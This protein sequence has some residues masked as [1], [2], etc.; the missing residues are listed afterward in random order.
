[1]AGAASFVLA[2]SILDGLALIGAP[3]PDIHPRLNLPLAFERSD[4]TQARYV[5]RGQGYMIA[6]D[7]AKATIAVV[8]LPN[9][10][11]SMITMQF[12]GGRRVLPVAGPE[13][14]GKVNY[15]RG[16][17][18]GK[19]KIGVPTCARVA[20]PNVYPGVDV[21]YYG[22]Q[23]QL[24]FDLV[25]K[26]G[27]D[28]Q[29]IRMKFDGA[30]EVSLDPNGDLVLD[31]ASGEI[32]LPSPR[33]YQETNGIRKTVAGHY[34]LRRR[35]EVGFEVAAYDRTS[36]LIIDPTIAFAAVFGGS[37]ESSAQ[38]IALNS[39]H[40][41]YVAGYTYAPDFPTT[42]GTAQPGFDANQ[43]GFVLELNAAGT[44]IIYST[45]L[46]GSQYD[47]LTGIAVDSTGA[48]WVTGNTSSLDFPLANPYQSAFNGAGP[49][50][51]VAK[52]SSSGTLEFSSYLLNTNPG[53]S[54]IAVDAGNN[55]YVTGQ[56]SINFPTTPGIPLPNASLS[57]AFVVKFTSGA[58]VVYSTLLGG[59][60]TDDAQ[61]IAA[62]S[63]GNA[64]VTGYTNSSDFTGDPGGGAHTA[65]A[66]GNDAFV[67][68]L[69]PSG[70][71][72]VYFTFLGGSSAD[73]SNAIAIDSNSP[74]NAYIGG[75]TSSTNFPS[76]AGVV[77]TT[78]T[79]GSNG[80]VAKLNGTGSAFTYVTYLGGNRSDS[81]AAL[82]LEPSSG[83]VYV[84]GSTDSSTLPNV[85]AVEGYPTN[86]TSLF[87]TTS[88]TSWSAFDT[89]IPGVVF[90]IA[91]DPVHSGTLVVSTDAGIYR[92]TNSGS[93]W[94][95]QSPVAKAF[96]SRSPANPST[97]YAMTVAGRS[98]LSTD[99]GVT[100]NY[101]G[102]VA[103]GYF[104]IIADPLNAGTAYAYPF[105]TTNSGVTWTDFPS[106]GPGGSDISTLFVGPD[107]TLYLGIQEYGVYQST[108][109]GSTWTAINTGLPNAC[110]PGYDQLSAS[111]GTSGNVLY[112]IC[113]GTVYKTTNGG[114][115][116]GPT[117]A[118]FANDLVYIMSSPTNPN[119]VYVTA[120]P[121]PVL[122]LSS[123]GGATWNSAATGLGIASIGSVVF[124]PSSANGAF[125]LAAAFSTG[126]VA[127]LK[128]AAKSLMY[129]SYLGGSAFTQPN[130]I[131][132]NG[133][134]EA[135]VAGSAYNLPIASTLPARPNF[136]N[137]FVAAITDATAACSY[138]IYP[139][140]QTIDGFS[141]V[142]QSPV[143]FGVNAPSGCAWTAT[144]NQSWATVTSGASGTGAGIVTVQAAANTT[145][146]MR[147]ASISINT[148]KATLIQA[149]MSCSFTLGLTPASGMFSSSGGSGQL[150]ISTSSGCPWEVA[151]DSPGALIDVTPTSGT[152]NGNV[153]FTVLP[154][155]GLNSRSL[156]VTVPEGIVELTQSGVCTSSF[157][158][159]SFSSNAQGGTTSVGITSSADGC[160]WTA[161][162]NADWLYGSSG[163][164]SGALVY[165]IATNTGAA[166]SGTLSLGNQTFTVNQA[167][168]TIS[169]VSV[170][171]NSE[172]NGFQT[173]AFSFDDPNGFADLAVVNVLINS[174]LDGIGACYIAFAP[175]SATSGYLYLV[176]DA[177]DG[178]YA[179]GS[180]IAFPWSG[181]LQNSQCTING[182]GS[183][184]SASGNTLTLTLSITF[185]SPSFAG[186]RVIYMAARNSSTGNS[187]WQPMGTWNVPGL[188]PTGPTVEGVV[189]ALNA[190]TGPTYSFTF[191]DTNGYP[192]LAVVNVL[193]N[194]SLDGIGA[195]YL[196]FAP[197]G[198]TTGYLYLVDDAGDGGYASGSPIALPSSGTLENSQ[199]A[200]SANGSSVSGNSNALTLN[201]VI[202]FSSSFA[203]NQV[204]Y[205][206]ARNNTTGNS[207]WQPVGSVTVP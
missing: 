93:T 178:G 17:D 21:V 172:S 2:L 186:N 50:G 133:M 143:T 57:H 152:G 192:D 165:S 167:A 60:G 37:E 149:A 112:A 119:L 25:L 75:S 99:N 199:C 190:T 193:I 104:P 77:Q 160:S 188:T 134:G 117:G 78:L 131:A 164:G 116:W 19:W 27:A 8:P 71:A 103:N 187:G 6:V 80:F 195:C 174:S 151:N 181:T 126:F 28:W 205:L 148:E 61:A 58:S 95:S 163:T 132:T 196:A 150:S 59:N 51:V 86:P 142:F 168:A 120:Y 189:P 136:T 32:R 183:S 33:I 15:I 206:A 108:D 135:F 157:D 79:G 115:N 105:L 40:N 109:Q 197:T 49:V 83:D 26:P 107:G 41:I 69:N 202:T 91:P 130:G 207:G 45:Y 87:K 158:T 24:E 35:D 106:A 74:P 179:N 100:W 114:A 81:V 48:A 185:N 52:L 156:E 14:P 194:G 177:G 140:S 154:N 88:G 128:S 46:G 122:Y 124:D 76:T 65:N 12:A 113:K 44:E 39:A 10:P 3:A 180:P 4:S 30:R 82:A 111:P 123:D 102:S 20:Y 101:E 129:S 145:G 184:V 139:E 90:S 16:N 97:I 200:V 127:K 153:T 42:S 201:L 62:D 73:Q 85:S 118:S 155:A 203:G 63:S 68:K 110:G 198:A 96:L 38:A 55:A 70:T 161:Y 166:R 162:G 5:A 72:L 146:A 121:A 169:P 98:Y 54:G 92:S 64:Y 29:S 22:N 84:A 53:G 18:P 138:S 56:G 31:T 191:N 13:L 204:F 66:G 171:P 176:D 147:S 159:S 67:A 23:R 182:T 1:M 137:G 173:F 89:N 11:G 94:T 141:P 43:D 125:A 144:S 175:S 170:S 34:T 9:Q 47:T 7:D 36:P